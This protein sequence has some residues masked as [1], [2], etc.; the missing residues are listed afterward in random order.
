MIKDT[1]DYH[2]LIIEDNPGDVTLIYDYLIEQIESPKIK[3]AKFF[4]QAV[5]YLKNEEP[6]DIILLDL[7]L[8]DKSGDEL[9]NDILKICGEAPVI[10]LTGFSDMEFSIRSI[11]LGVSDYLLKND[12]TASSLYKSILYCLER[13]KRVHE[14]KESEK[15]YSDLFRLN[16][17]PIWIYELEKFKFVQVNRAAIELYGYTIEEFLNLTVFDLKVEEDK[18][19]F[20]ETLKQ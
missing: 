4:L 18:D 14:L 1:N 15:R 3:N 11:S 10:I 5:E 19:S 13:K 12:L 9:I 6:F 8:P 7:S 2:I 20:K 17:Q 16:P